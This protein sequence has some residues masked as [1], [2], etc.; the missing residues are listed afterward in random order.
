MTKVA[1]YG[2]HRSVRKVA[3][4]SLS[5]RKVAASSCMLVT[6]L[7]AS[8]NVQS[9]LDASTV[10][11]LYHSVSIFRPVLEG[12]QVRMITPLPVVFKFEAHPLGF[13]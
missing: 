7:S 10:C 5:S 11:T 1:V 3:V 8:I 9:S 12:G 2:V 13:G 6:T 4:F